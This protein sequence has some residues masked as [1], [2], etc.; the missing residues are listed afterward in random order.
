MFKKGDY[1]VT[2]KVLKGD[3]NCARDNYCF[4]QRINNKSIY[5]EVDLRGS[6][7]N[8]HNIMSFDKQGYLKDWRYATPQE[9]KEYDRIGKPYDITTLIPK[10]I[11]YKIY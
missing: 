3:Y 9:I 6:K 8:G 11:K 1:I 4:K 7:D 2:L 5:P 10:K